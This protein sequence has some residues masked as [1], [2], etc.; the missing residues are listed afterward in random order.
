MHHIV[1]NMDLHSSCNDLF[2]K[3]DMELGFAV[4]CSSTP[5]LS[6]N[7]HSHILR[8][9]RVQAQYALRYDQQYRSWLKENP[10]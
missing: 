4:T 9:F 5:D 6:L 2:E 7:M 3:A 8:I 1:R 10:R